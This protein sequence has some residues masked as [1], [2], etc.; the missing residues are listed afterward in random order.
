M[1]VFDRSSDGVLVGGLDDVLVGELDG[2]LVLLATSV[3]VVVMPA[4]NA[5]YSLIL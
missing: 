4:N 1:V 2:G 5:C 3:G